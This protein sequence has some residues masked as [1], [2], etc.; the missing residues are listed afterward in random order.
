MNKNH[1]IHKAK[2]LDGLSQDERAYLIN[3][4]QLAYCLNRIENDNDLTGW[5]FFNPSEINKA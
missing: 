5:R 2:A 4:R 3:L 1:L